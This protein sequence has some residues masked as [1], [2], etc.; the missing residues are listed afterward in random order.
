MP[1][2]A[3][4]GLNR[5]TF[6]MRSS[7]L[8][9][10]VYGASLLTPS[11]FLDGIASAAAA[12]PNQPVLVSI[13]MQGGWDALSVLA[14]V[15]DPRYAALRPTLSL[16]EGTGPTFSE[17]PQLMWHPA[18]GGLATLHGEGKVTTFPAIGYDPPDESHSRAA[19]T[20]GRELS[21]SASTG[22]LAAISMSPAARRTR[23]RASRSTTASP[24]AGHRR[25]SGRRGLLPGRLP[26]LGQRPR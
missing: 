21:G 10:S 17:D 3:G 12:T 15:G 4:T 22:W 7:G 25:Q 18:A 19:T 23:S 20:G 2:P 9:L 11:H 1:R 14:P 6:L 24:R 8:A 5:R 13:F 16:A 26:L